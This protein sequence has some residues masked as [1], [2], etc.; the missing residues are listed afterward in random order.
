MSRPSFFAGALVLLCVLAIA[1]RWLTRSASSEKAAL[2]TVVPVSA[3]AAIRARETEPPEISV[4]P[5]R[6]HFVGAGAA[7][8]SKTAP[9]NK[10]LQTAA[11]SLRSYRITFHENPG[12]TN[13]EIT[14]KL[15]GKNSRGLRLLPPDVLV[16]SKG[17]LV[18]QWNQPLFFHQISAKIM[19]VRSAGPDQRMWNG[20]D[21]ILR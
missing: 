8:P 21:E 9:A 20:D 1:G 10:A 17:E 16:N 18:D 6:P 13:A 19:E 14:D 4:V 15:L 2:P 3:A 5:D 12:G 7:L 11:G